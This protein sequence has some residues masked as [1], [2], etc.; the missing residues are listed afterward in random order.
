[1]SNV[2]SAPAWQSYLVG[3]V[4]TVADGREFRITNIETRR[5]SGGYSSRLF[6]L[7][8]PNGEVVVK[9]S[10]ALTLWTQGK[11]S[12]EP[13]DLEAEATGSSKDLA[14]LL[15]EAVSPYV[16]ASASDTHGVDKAE[17]AKIVDERLAA[18]VPQ[19][20]E[21]VQ[22]DGTVNP[23]G[24]QHTHF[25]A[26]LRIVACRLCAWLVGPA[27]SGKTSA[28]KSVADALT[29]PFYATSVGPQ[30]SQSQLLG[31]YDANGAYVTTQL[32]QAYE[33][34]GVFLLD[35]VD[36]GSAAVLVVINALLANGH[37]AFPDRVVERHPDFVLLAG[38]N[39]IGQ[40]ADR[41]YVGRQQADAATLD[42]F[43][44]LPWDYDPQIEAA[45]CG[46]PFDAFSDAPKP[47]GRKFLSTADRE[48]VEERC[49]EYCRKVVSIRNA[50]E[51]LGKGVRFLCGPRASIHGCKLIRA[52][53]S[54]K[55]TLDCCVWKGCDEDTKKKIEARC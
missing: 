43:V 34:G 46:V 25:E 6:T 8:G 1:M 30:T 20:I 48:N 45:A 2:A 53:F 24:V 50:V 12:D 10:R 14:A 41:Q 15:A 39:T 44:A 26:L 33:H 35:E 22:L 54:V 47:K 52:G 18:L 7:E 27:G 32:R 3:T 17:V 11:G 16:T 9:T 19:R 55:D 42:R 13:S 31:Y 28:A 49:A 23:V 36:A 37:A 38:A 40:G 5:T 29:L 4:V 51:G 21:V